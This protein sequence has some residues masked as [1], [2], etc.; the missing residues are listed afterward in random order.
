MN[1]GVDEQHGAWIAGRAVANLD[2][3]HARRP[4]AHAP[5]F[6]VSFEPT[7][8]TSFKH[9]ARRESEGPFRDA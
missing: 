8:T 1:V 3:G 6:V 9:L 7:G 4:A 5:S 2:L